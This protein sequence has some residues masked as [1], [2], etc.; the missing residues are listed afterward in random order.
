VNLSFIILIIFILILFVTLWN[1]YI[2]NPE[3]NVSYSVYFYL[4]IILAA[5][6]VIYLVNIYQ[7]SEIRSSEIDI[8]EAPLAIRN[9]DK[10]TSGN[11]P[12]ESFFA[13]DIEVDDMALT[14]IPKIEFKEPVETYTEKI[15]QNLAKQFE[16]VLGIFY[17][18]DEK[19]SYFHP[20][21]TYAWNSDVP[22]AS[23]E[24]GEGLTGQ[25]AKNKVLMKVDHIPDDYIKIISG[26]GTGSPKNLLI[27]PLLLNKET[28]GIIELASFKEFDKVTEWTI[29][30]LSKIIANSVITKL[31]AGQGK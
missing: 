22:P 26:L 5:A 8:K 11:Q 2:Q 25:V 13:P 20:V 9:S 1:R 15:L 6:V 28:I 19:T 29:K 7:A 30:Y 12:A 27:V 10:N 17:L 4:L 18:K 14:I 21:S 31:K 16:L 23:F 3:I 24:M